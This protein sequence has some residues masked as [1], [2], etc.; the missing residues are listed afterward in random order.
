MAYVF[1]IEKPE[2]SQVDKK[3]HAKPRNRT[4]AHQF[5]G[6]KRSGGAIGALVTQ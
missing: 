1:F 2:Y 6:I 3:I 5:Q 4:Q